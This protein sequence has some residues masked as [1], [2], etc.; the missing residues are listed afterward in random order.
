LIGVSHEPVVDAA[1]VV[2]DTELSIKEKI[3]SAISIL[4]SLGLSSIGLVE[5]F[6]A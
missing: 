2:V 1:V 3:D 5:N 4:Q 6:R